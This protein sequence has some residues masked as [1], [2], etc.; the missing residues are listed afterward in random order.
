MKLAAIYNVW[1]DWDL[2][3]HSIENIFQVVDGIIVV[4]SRKSNSGELSD[5]PNDLYFPGNVELF[6]REPFASQA[7]HCETDKRNFGLQKARE[8]GYTHFIMMDVDEFYEPEAFLKEKQRFIDNPN[9]AGLV[10]AS[11]VYVKSPTLT[12]G[13]DTTLVPFIHKITSGLKH[14]FNRNYPY[15]WE[16]RN[17][18]IDPTRSININSGVEWSPIVMHHM[19]YVRTDL[20]RKIRNST[21]KSNIEKSTIMEDYRNAKDGY[22]FKFYNKK[23][24]TVDNIF[25]LPDMID[26]SI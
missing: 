16:G 7:M 26:L 19:S 17:I 21:A 15:A 10:C 9:L 20:K 13:L 25:N 2:L 23:L 14:E 4:Y 12:I 5:P 22:Y 6:Q 8:L 24:F 3:T 11:Q 18:R 1:A